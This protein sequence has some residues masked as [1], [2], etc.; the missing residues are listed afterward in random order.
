MVLFV[1]AAQK[2]LLGG[3][4]RRALE[5]LSA[6]HSVHTSKHL[7]PAVPWNTVYS[8]GPEEGTLCVGEGLR[9]P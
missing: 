5:L 7:A 9:V 3:R 1:L 8:R 6:T 4:S 2:G